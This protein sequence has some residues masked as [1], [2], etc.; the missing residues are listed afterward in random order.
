MITVR[1]QVEF[2]AA[3]RMDV[4]SV[5]RY[6]GREQAL[7][8]SK[9]LWALSSRRMTVIKLVAGIRLFYGY[10]ELCETTAV[11]PEQYK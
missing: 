11:G 4:D 10:H 3:F 8:V 6:P 2:P 5:A 9:I 1:C 7:A